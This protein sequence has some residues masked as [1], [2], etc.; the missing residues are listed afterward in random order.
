MAAAS[1][2]T[3][4]IA[5][6]A[7]SAG[8]PTAWQARELQ[9][10]RQDSMKAADSRGVQLTA[11]DLTSLDIA[12]QPGLARAATV[13]GTAGC[14]SNAYPQ[15]PYSADAGSWLSS[16]PVPP[17]QGP[18]KSSALPSAG[19]PV[20]QLPD[21]YSWIVPAP[22]AGSAPMPTASPAQ[23]PYAAATSS[24]S[25]SYLPP[26]P[27][28]PSAARPNSNVSSYPLQSVG[29]AQ[30]SDL[31]AAPPIPGTAAPA[32]QQQQ[33]QWPSLAAGQ[34]HFQQPAAGG[35]VAAV[36]ATVRTAA[37]GDED[38]DG[39]GPSSADDDW[40]DAAAARCVMHG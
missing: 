6:C 20:Q 22:A 18:A 30:L 28:V 26:Y 12:V 11:P 23:A 14:G 21:Y 29:S 3:S 31:P 32:R 5:V 13:A 27:S 2:S 15:V 39:W 34:P 8:S 10:R 17:V 35:A 38:E 36:A 40:G 7:A 33:Q 1:C 9:Q 37:A 4:S 24:I 16:L 25:D 19:V